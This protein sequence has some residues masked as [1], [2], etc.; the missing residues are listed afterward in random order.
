M[1][2]GSAPLSAGKS[3]HA[4]SFQSKAF[5]TP[6]SVGKGASSFVFTGSSVEEWIE[7]KTKF[8]TAFHAI[9]GFDYVDLL[10]NP[11]P[12]PL[13]LHTPGVIEF[14]PVDPIDYQFPTISQPGNPQQHDYNV[15]I[16]AVQYDHNVKPKMNKRNLYH[17]PTN[18]KYRGQNMQIYE[19]IVPRFTE[20][21][22]SSRW[23]IFNF[24]RETLQKLETA[25]RDRVAT[26]QTINVKQNAIDQLCNT[27]STGFKAAIKEVEDREKA[28]AESWDKQKKVFDQRIGDCI[29]VFHEHMTPEAIRMIE[30]LLS[31]RKV[32]AAWVTLLAHYSDDSDHNKAVNY[33]VTASLDSVV[34]DI[35]EPFIHF[36]TQLES[37]FIRWETL[38]GT[39][40]TDTMKL[41]YLN[42]A[43]EKCKSKDFRNMA[44][45]A[46]MDA[47]ADYTTMKDRMK[48]MEV[49]LK[50]SGDF[51]NR[52]NSGGGNKTHQK[53]HVATKASKG[54]KKGNDTS[55]AKW[56][57]WCNKNVQHTTDTCWSQAT[58]EY[59]GKKGHVADRCHAL[60]KDMIKRNKDKGKKNEDLSNQ[61]K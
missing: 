11:V 9:N 29:K 4:S 45:F 57:K 38:N 37:L 51:I 54:S 21:P 35:N 28:A 31:E 2:S 23:A 59:C 27:I 49:Q 7:T 60:R 46:M 16:T 8:I 48:R 55:T 14:Q 61:G 39:V 3:S 33:S 10:T 42:R 5:T 44:T 22:E 36:V 15:D 52:N 6:V 40:M 58:C 17:L 43:L 13:D 20:V 24:K 34:Y 18:V 26:N 30:T 50:T 41:H 56:C 25:C 1:N 12:D 19:N 53:A 47:G 32:R